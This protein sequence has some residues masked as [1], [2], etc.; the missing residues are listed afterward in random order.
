MA[1]STD[2]RARRFRKVLVVGALLLGSFGFANVPADAATFTWSASCG[3]G[4]F[5]DVGALAASARVLQVSSQCGVKAQVY[6][7][8]NT[9]ATRWETAWG[10]KYLGQLSTEYCSSPYNFQ[11][12]GIGVLI[13]G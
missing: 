7:Q 10:W 1:G 9:G 2:F 6:C 11:R 4:D 5:Y 8:R 12:L 13:G 3:S